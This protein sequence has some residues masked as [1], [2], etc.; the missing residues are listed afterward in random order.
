MLDRFLTFPMQTVSVACAVLQ[1]TDG[2]LLLAKRPPGKSLA[3]F[4]E[5]PGGKIEAH[6]NAQT[7]LV[8]ELREE[9]LLETKVLEVLEA[10]HHDYADFSIYLIP[11]RVRLLSGT[12]IPMEHSEIA[13]FNPGDIDLTT[14][15]PA[16]VPV[17][18]QL[19]GK[20]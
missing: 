13:W 8:R 9:L 15:A 3:G 1:D 10:V 7:A 20:Q 4:W 2:R 17:L 16:D 19:L 6:E 11:C 18:H 14:L 12:P 5:F